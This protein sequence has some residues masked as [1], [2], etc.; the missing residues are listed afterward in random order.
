MTEDDV[1]EHPTKKSLFELDCGLS[2]E[3]MRVWIYPLGFF[4]KLIIGLKWPLD[5]E[6]NAP[7]FARDRILGGGSNGGAGSSNQGGRG[8]P[9]TNN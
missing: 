1:L 8:Y 5:S 9:L 2:I 7:S 3:D 4:R 6:T